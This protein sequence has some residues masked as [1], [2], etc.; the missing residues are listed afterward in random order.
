MAQTCLIER[1]QGI[2]EASEPMTSAT[3]PH[4]QTSE[5]TLAFLLFPIGPFLPSHLHCPMS[6]NRLLLSLAK[7]YPLRSLLAVCLGFSSALFN[8]VSTALIVPVVLSL[9]GQDLDIGNTPPFL[10]T[11]LSPFDAVAPTYRLLVMAGAV[12]VAI[13]LKNLTSYANIV[14]ASSLKQRLTSDLREEALGMILAVDIDY[15]YKLGAGDILNRINNEIGRTANA[16]SAALRILVNATTVFVFGGLLVAISWQLTIVASMLLLVVVALNQLFINRSK[17]FGKQLSEASKAYSV[18]L[19]ESLTG[20]RLIKEVASESREYNTLVSLIRRRERIEFLAQANSAAIAPVSEM[21]GIASLIGIVAFGRIFFAEQLTA[22][23]TLLLTYLVVLFRLLPFLSQLNSSRSLF[24]NLSA[25]VEI[26]VNFLNP[27]DKPFMQSGQTPFQGLREA[28]AFENVSFAYPGTDRPSLKKVSLTLPKGTTLALVGE[29]GAGKSTLADL[30]PRFYDPNEGRIT[31]DGEDVRSFDLGSLR[32]GIGIV[33]QESFLFN[34][35]I[36][37][38]VAYARPA[39]TDEEIIDALKRAN[40]F[41]F[42]SQLPQGLDTQIGDR[43]VML[44]GGQRQRL[45]IARA[46]LKDAEILILDEATSALDTVSEKLVQTAIENLSQERTSLVIAHRLST[47]QSAHQ[48]AVLDQ[49]EVVEVG[50]HQELLDQDGYYAR[51]YAMQFSTQQ[52]NI[53]Q[54]HDLHALHQA[55]M[56]QTS[57][58]MRDNLNSVLGALS[59]VADDV[60]VDPEEEDILMKEAYHSAIALFKSLEALEERALKACD[61]RLS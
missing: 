15:F 21:A 49:G 1:G 42:V 28:I 46:L 43:G 48:I 36:R 57:H 38:N 39:A 24:A 8:G 13:G 10:R 26:V 37:N 6:R 54:P 2:R 4:S 20:I 25:S 5:P 11:L 17:A 35:S 47:I 7:R 58:V 44:S 18:R 31:L 22:I 52:G 30:L 12:L 60:I 61:G 29:S 40:A 53:E 50:T 34:D 27:S 56:R 33:S 45:S 41:D 19:T 16:V 3:T 32:R 59:L 14:T 55:S 23:A 51:L 9:L